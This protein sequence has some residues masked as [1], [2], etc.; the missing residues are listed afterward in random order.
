MA[1]LYITDQGV[2]ISKTDGR[3]IVRKEGK[4]LQDIPAFKV[5]QVVIFGNAHITTPAV[6]FF[7]KRGIDVAYLSSRGKYKGR[8]Q[9]E[10]CKDATLRQKQY[11]CSLDPN[12]CLKV[13]KQIVTGKIQNMITFCQR[14]R[15]KEKDWKT[16]LQSMEQVMNQVSKAS[17]HDSLWGYEGTASATYY[18]LFR[19][20]L[21]EDWGFTKRIAHPP[22]DPINV[23]LSLGYTLLYNAFYAAINVV[24]MDPYLGFFHQTRHG[25]AT[26][27]SDLMEEF[28]SIIVDSVVLSAVNKEVIKRK[29]F[30]GKD[31]QIRISDEGL[32]RFLV[33]Y[34]QRMNTTV[35]HPQLK[36]Q[37][38]YHRCIE[39]QVRHFARVIQGEDPVYYSFKAR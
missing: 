20:F 34:D 38:S 18:K 22:T 33:L 30:N 1:I 35:I 28:R 37:T 5:S 10:F 23:L 31:S 11:E 17:N 9:P 21:P 13:S 39:L 24:G 15:G 14:Q 27:A 36:P 32:K 8:L 19:T 2:T 16:S 4:L 25:H 3:I 6:G 12:F 26:L 29:D 7:L